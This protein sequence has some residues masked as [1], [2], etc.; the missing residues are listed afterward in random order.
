MTQRRASVNIVSRGAR[1]QRL[2]GRNAAREEEFMTVGVRHDDLRRRN[3]A[4]VLTAVRRAGQLSRTDLTSTTRL[5]HSTISAIS[6]DLIAEGILTEVASGEVTATRRGRPQIALGLNAE[7]ARVVAITLSLNS[8]SVTLIDYAGHPVRQDRSRPSTLTLSKSALLKAVTDAVDRVIGRAGPAGGELMRMTMA[9]QGITDSEARVMA[10]SPITPHVAVPFGATLEARYGVPVSVENDCN[11]IAIALRDRSPERY[12]EDFV[13]L[14][15]SNGI[16]TG[17]VLRGE[18]FTGTHSSGAEFGHMIHMPRGALCRCGRHGCIEA[19]AGNYAIY[20]HAR[21]ES[22]HAAPAADIDDA[23]MIALADAA[24]AAPGPERAAFSAAGEAIGYG[25]GS[26]FAIIDPA[27]VAL[28][29]LGS[30]AFDILEPSMR[31]AIAATAGGQYVDAVTFEL[32]KDEA[33]L[34]REGCARRAL[35]YVDQEV[36]ALAQAEAGP[37]VA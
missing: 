12:G 19:Y 34:I 2:E 15:L 30:T 8:L 32:E 14:L 13:A 21:G 4:M 20:R 24:R 37:R 3:R 17:L 16:G 33:P 10:W 6:S 26:L 35:T 5:S 31:R 11:M 22:E 7:A 29:G 9:V 36:F 1:V 18:L 23:T 25:L 28:V 27:P